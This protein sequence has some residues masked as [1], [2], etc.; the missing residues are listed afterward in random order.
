MYRSTVTVGL[1]SA[2]WMRLLSGP[3]RGRETGCTR[4]GDWVKVINTV[5]A[6]GQLIVVQSRPARS[7]VPT[8]G[9]EIVPLPAAAAG[10]DEGGGREVL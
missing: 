8:P 9:A 1:T 3:G 6:R 2:F 4:V 7:R 10:S 5:D